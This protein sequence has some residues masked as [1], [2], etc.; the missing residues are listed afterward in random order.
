MDNRRLH[1]VSIFIVIVCL[2]L[3]AVAW[4]GQDE[5]IP[6][7]LSIA[8][9]VR[10]KQRSI[11]NAQFHVVVRNISTH[12]VNLWREWCS[13]GYFSLSFEVT[14]ENGKNWIVKKKDRGWDKNY[15]DSCTVD[16]NGDLV[17]DVT[18][19][20]DTWENPPRPEAGKSLTVTLR[21]VFQVRETEESKKHEVWTGKV[22]SE[23][24]QYTF[25]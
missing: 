19:N 5:H 13:W 21:A 1:G 14:D 8:V 24:K 11:E 22:V 4:A 25:W 17:I 9:P 6:L 15:P 3:G 23:A 20:P 7:S 12:N 18:L 10:G 2:V 16:P